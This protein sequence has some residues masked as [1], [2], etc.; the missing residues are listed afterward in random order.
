MNSRTTDAFWKRYRRLPLEVRRQ[1]VQAYRLWRQNP[2]LPGLRF[3]LMH[4]ATRVYSVRVND[5]Y[6]ALGRL[7]GDTM[8]W[9]FIGTH[10]DYMGT[11]S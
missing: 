3:K 1:A 6:R 5:S 11:L 8:I 10:D 2:R 9:F 4:A 7:E